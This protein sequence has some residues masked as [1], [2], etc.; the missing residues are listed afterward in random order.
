MSPLHA[1]T[2][3]VHM[4]VAICGAERVS[5]T[6]LAK[7]EAIAADAYRDIG[8]LIEWR[9]ACGDARLTVHLVASDA[10]DPR[11]TVTKLALGY[12]QPGTQAA[13]VLYD[14]VATFAHTYHVTRQVL[15]G[16]T[17]AHE[18]GHLLLPPNSHSNSGVM[19]SSLDLERAAARRL[20]FTR[21]QGVLIVLRLENPAMSVATN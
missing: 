10:A 6:E 12:A 3:A 2:L 15:L 16:Y 4:T 9:E 13:T 21:G 18:L 19:R 5:G 14:R 11:V 20:R 8:V 7:A 17:I 1:L